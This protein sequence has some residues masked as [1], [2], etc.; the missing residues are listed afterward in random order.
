[1]GVLG[2]EDAEIKEVLKERERLW[3]PTSKSM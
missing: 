3:K 1:M 2:I